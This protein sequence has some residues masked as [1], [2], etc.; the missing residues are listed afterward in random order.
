[1][2]VQEFL[3][4]K[5]GF[6]VRPDVEDTEEQASS[7]WRAIKVFLQ[8][9]SARKM[10]GEDLR[11]MRHFRESADYYP[12]FRGVLEEAVEEVLLKAEKIIRRLKVLV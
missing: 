9:S 3:V 11:R 2:Q 4:R 1:M 6:K 5:D 7:H 10:V 8:G 12:E